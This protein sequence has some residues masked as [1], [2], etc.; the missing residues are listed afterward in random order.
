M[1]SSLVNLAQQTEEHAT[2]QL[3]MPAIMFGVVAFAIL[4]LLLLVTMAY[5]NVHTRHR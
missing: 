3:P 1:M 4:M 5:R 2:T